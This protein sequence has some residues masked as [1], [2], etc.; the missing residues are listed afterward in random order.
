MQKTDGKDSLEISDPADDPEDYRSYEVVLNKAPS[1]DFVHEHSEEAHGH[2]HSGIRSLMLVFSL[3]M[4]S[5]LEGIA[6]GLQET[7]GSVV[8]IFAAVLVH[9]SLIA[10]SMGTNLVHSSQT[11][12]KIIAAACI[13]AF[14]SPVGILIGLL[15]E[16]T[17]T[18][19]DSITL[20]NAIL[21]GLATG[22][23]VYIAFFEVLVKEFDEHRNRLT[24]LFSLLAG[25]MIIFLKNIL[26]RIM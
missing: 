7:A 8:A 15:L 16:R 21:Q 6:I 18:E 14:M 20:V 10:F 3:S 23:F 11:K 12:A 4:H 24:K 9:K 22:T 1:D 17:G 13:F 25:F 5:L 2:D 26:R 19:N